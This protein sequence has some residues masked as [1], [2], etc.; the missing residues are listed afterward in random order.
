MRTSKN[1]KTYRVKKIIKTPHKTKMFITQC[2]DSAAMNTL[3][4]HGFRAFRTTVA[5]NQIA[6]KKIEDIKICFKCYTFESH[7]TKECTSTIKI[8]FNCPEQEHALHKQSARNQIQKCINCKRSGE[9]YNHHT[10]ST[11]WPAR[12]ERIKKKEENIQLLQAQQQQ[13]N[14]AAAVSFNHNIANT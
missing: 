11:A 2:R 14:F 5:P 10:L 13:Q 3:L 7:S 6:L 4:N 8:C 12:L 9:P 1:K